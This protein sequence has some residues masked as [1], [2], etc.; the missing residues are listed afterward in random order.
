MAEASFLPRKPQGKCVLILDGHSSHCSNVEMLEFAE[1]NEII[2]ICLLSHT[3]HFLQPLDRTFFKSLKCFYYDECNKFIT[4]N[5][6]R[7]LSRLQFGKILA[8]AWNK[9]ASVSNATSGFSATGIV[10]FNANAIPDYAFLTPSNENHDNNL[11]T[12]AII[13]HNQPTTESALSQPATVQ[14]PST[15]EAVSPK[16]TPG[17]ILDV[18]SPIPIMERTANVRHR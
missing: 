15:S 8:S 9:S 5:P 11:Q 18:V 14:K 1:E 3:T 4:T 12:V 7:K 6:S 13:Q 17:K 2:L 16:A 10:P